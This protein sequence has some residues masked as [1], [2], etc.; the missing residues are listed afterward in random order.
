MVRITAK[1][2]LKKIGEEVALKGWV[3]TVR[4]HGKIAFLDLRDRSGVIQVGGFDPDVVSVISSLNLQDVI[5]VVGLAKKRDEKYINKDSELGSIEVEAKDVKLIQKAGEMPFDMGGKSLNLELPTLLDYRTLTLRHPKV[6]AIFKVQAALMEGF[7]RAAKELDCEEV[8]VPTISASATE[9]GAELFKFK[10]YDHEAFL[11]QSP[12]L[13]KQMMVGIFER[14]FLTSH[15]YRA[16]PSVTT[17]HLAE[18]IQMDFE[19]GFIDSFDELLDALEFAFSEMIKYAQKACSNELKLLGVEPSKVYKK[20]P[21]LTMRE[22]Q[23]LIFKRTGVDH[24]HELDLMPEDEKELAAWARDE[25]D[26]DLVTI[27]H[28]P[29]KKR[30]FYSKPDSE[31]PE[32][33]LS[34]D[35]LYKGLEVSSGAQRIDD[36]KVLIQT[37]KSRG[38]DPKGFAM[39]IQAF[40]YGMPPHGGF[41]Y[42]L[43]RTTMKLLDLAN[44]REASLF[45]RDME[46]V[47]ERLSKK[48]EKT[49]KKT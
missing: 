18:S 21:R 13:Y 38:M 8:F 45:P 11:V 40:T 33:S 7:R 31:N 34:Y 4:S 27:T 3:Q 26:S 14:V 44:I 30:A 36:V 39:Y 1:E 35:L 10:Y 12:Q 29:T 20:I 37:I 17:R 32:Y 6:A 41:S 25:H 9:G 28:F 24:R 19:I 23:E 5:E 48:E 2:T 43:E 22:A 15:I 46:R 42:G 49:T 16:E 47:D